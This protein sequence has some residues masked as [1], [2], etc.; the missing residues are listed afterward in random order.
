MDSPLVSPLQPRKGEIV[1]VVDDMKTIR[2]LV[3]LQLGQLGCEPQAFS[4]G[5]PCLEALTQK[6]P[7][8]ILMDL[9]M[10]PMRGDECCRQ[11]KESE[12]LSHIPIVMLTG[13]DAAH[14]IMHSWRAGA[15]DFLPKPVRLS[16]LASK[17]QALRTS[18]PGP[19][20]ARGRSPSRQR[21][22]YLENRPF[23]RTRLGGALEHAGFKILYCKDA[24]DTIRCLGTHRDEIDLLICELGALG[25]RGLD[26]ARELRQRA[27]PQI[28]M[29]LMSAV[30]QSPEVQSAVRQLTGHE[31]LNKRVLPA[32]AILAKIN[33]L[34]QRVTLDVRPS[35]RVPF[36][37]VVAFHADTSGE[38]L[39]GFAYDVST[40]G[41]FIRTMTPF[42][43]LSDVEMKVRF[44]AARDSV[45]CRGVVAWANPFQSRSAFSYPLGMGVRFT[46]LDPES[47][48]MV[49]KLIQSGG[50]SSATL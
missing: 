7:K 13:A 36:F 3:C 1:F 29:L 18:A 28:P 43:P 33:S 39:S 10:G 46:E 24:A 30:D 9:G 50:R 15:D 41:I 17:I 26:E 5:E 2:D 12:R 14:E 45:S 40:G 8:L 4:G 35:E 42:P 44:F 27:S 16:Q 48:K 38:W 21:L 31:L 37:S 47:G 22:L 32:E 6:E 23:H 49:A 20:S 25:I 34:L 19:D 11:I